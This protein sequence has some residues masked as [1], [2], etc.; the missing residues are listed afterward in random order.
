ML[1]FSPSKFRLSGISYCD[2]QLWN[3]NL[4]G[5]QYIGEWKWKHGI[6]NEKANTPHD[7]KS[8]NILLIDKRISIFK[9]GHFWK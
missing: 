4:I 1:M 6:W 9:M 5:D 8:I 3:I 2:L 7:T